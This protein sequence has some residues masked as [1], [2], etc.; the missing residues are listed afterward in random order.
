MDAAEFTRRL[1]DLSASEIDGIARAIRGMLGSAEG[2]VSWWKATI[3][4]DKALRLH[5]QGRLASRA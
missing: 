2:E 3:T 4:V 5:G 1:E